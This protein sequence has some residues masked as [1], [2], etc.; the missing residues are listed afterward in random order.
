VLELL[1]LG[2]QQVPEAFNVFDAKVTQQKLQG[3]ITP[4]SCKE[5][6]G[7]EFWH[8]NSSE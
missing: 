1:L 4:V 6:F 2:W 5:V 7:S 3:M 8:I